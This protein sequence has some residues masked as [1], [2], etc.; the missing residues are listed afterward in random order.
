MHEA[1]SMQEA[2]R[3]LSI[4]QAMRHA[5]SA[6]PEIQEAYQNKLLKTIIGEE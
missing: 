6:E 5:Q 4:F 2:R 3:E 1:L